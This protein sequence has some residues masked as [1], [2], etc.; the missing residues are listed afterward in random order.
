MEPIKITAI[1]SQKTECKTINFRYLRNRDHLMKGVI[2]N[3]SPIPR[4]GMYQQR[5]RGTHVRG[6]Q[7]E[8]HI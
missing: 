7:Q 8:D 2:Q 6:Y 4:G 3:V 5:V 1:Y